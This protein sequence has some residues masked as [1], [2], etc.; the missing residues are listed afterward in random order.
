MLTLIEKFNR[1]ANQPDL[2]KLLLRVG[3]AGMFL[4]H[5]VHKALH[6]T[7]FV[8]GLFTNLGLPAELAYLAFIG[9]ILAPIAIIAG[10]FTRIFA[11]ICVGNCLVIMFL[12]HASHF[13]TLTKVG[14]WSVESIATFFVGFLAVMLLGSGKYAVRAD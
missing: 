7:D 9:E 12:M 5:G 8:Q 3:F 6:G 10:V 14:A 4:L 13:F 2:A 11:S 1:T